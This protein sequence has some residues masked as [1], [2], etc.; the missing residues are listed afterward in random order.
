MENS[1][2]TFEEI[3]SFFKG[4]SGNHSG[5][6]NSQIY[7]AIMNNQMKYYVMSATFPNYE[8]LIHMKQPTQYH[9]AGYGISREEALIRLVGESI[10]RYSLVYNYQ[11]L[12]DNVLRTTYNNLKKCG[13]NVMDLEFLNVFSKNRKMECK[14]GVKGIDFSEGISHTK[15]NDNIGWFK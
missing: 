13:K 7:Q 6:L 8:K 9:L 12:K 1:L 4:I 15:S 3:F 14:F 10:E 5:I 11:W 2:K